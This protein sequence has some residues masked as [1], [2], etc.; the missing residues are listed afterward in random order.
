MKPLLLVLLT[1]LPIGEAWVQARRT[2]SPVP[3]TIQNPR[4][5]KGITSKVKQKQPTLSLFLSVCEAMPSFP[6]GQDSLVAY[7]KRNLRYPDSTSDEGKVFIGFVITKTGHIT[8]AK[9]LK[10]VNSTLDAEALRVVRQMPRWIQ[11][12]RQHPIEVSYTIP[13][14]FSRK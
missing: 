4:P 10:G 14:T 2:Y 7:I 9:V 12:Y 11:P 8:Q 3:E 5:A 13:I 1:C 6:G